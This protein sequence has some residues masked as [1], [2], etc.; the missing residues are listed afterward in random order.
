MIVTAIKFLKILEVL[1][2]SRVQIKSNLVALITVSH[3]CCRFMYTLT[4]Q[5][6]HQVIENVPEFDEGPVPL[7][8]GTLLEAQSG[9]YNYIILFGSYKNTGEPP[10]ITV[11]NQISNK[12]SLVHI[13]MGLIIVSSILSL[14]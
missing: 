6:F 11:L 13:Y 7:S 5:A 3:F 8:S 10:S 1:N 4:F 12:S 9:V 2:N 14:N